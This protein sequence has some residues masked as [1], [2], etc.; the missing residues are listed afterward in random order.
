MFIPSCLCK[1]DIY[2]YDVLQ[3]MKQDAYV[4]HLCAKYF[5][6]I[7]FL[8]LTK[9]IS[10]HLC[11]E[12]KSGLPLPSSLKIFPMFF[13]LGNVFCPKKQWIRESVSPPR[14][15][16]GFE[17]GKRFGP[18]NPKKPR[19]LALWG[20]SKTRTKSLTFWMS[21]ELGGLQLQLLKWWV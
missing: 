6:Y 3:S 2:D 13:S 18:P 1:Q 17:N 20:E 8:F 7:L 4:K 19:H 9:Q 15:L 11:F 12:H 21:R 5:S 16:Q 14:Q 10:K